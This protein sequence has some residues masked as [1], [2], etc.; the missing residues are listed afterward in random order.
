[1]PGDPVLLLAG[2]LADDEAVDT[3]RRRG[4]IVV[5]VG[6]DGPAADVRV[7]LPTPA[8]V[9]PLVRSLVEPAVAELLAWELWRRAS[10]VEIPAS[11]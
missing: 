5:A 6:P 1:M 4:G 2:S 11:G 10:A 9:D 3:V 8:L 7:P